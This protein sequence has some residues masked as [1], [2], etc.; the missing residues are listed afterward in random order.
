MPTSAL[1]Q[2]KRKKHAKYSIN[3]FGSDLQ[4]IRKNNHPTNTKT[5]AYPVASLFQ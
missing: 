3:G 1:K 2:R 5:V 4:S